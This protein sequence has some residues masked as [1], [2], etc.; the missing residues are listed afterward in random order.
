MKAGLIVQEAQLQERRR[1]LPKAAKQY[2]IKKLLPVTIKK[3]ITF[4]LTKGAV[5]RSFG[6]VRNVIGLVSVFKKQ[7]DKGVKN[8]LL[9]TAKKVGAAAAVKGIMNFIRNRK[10]HPSPQ[11]IEVK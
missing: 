5:V 11:K 10:H 9:N 2:A 1:H 7:K 6:L 8:T 4:I 3:V